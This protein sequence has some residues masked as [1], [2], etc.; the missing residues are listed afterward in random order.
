MFP[1]WGVVP[2]TE[3][4]QQKAAAGVLIYT[5]VSSKSIGPRTF[6]CYIAKIQDLAELS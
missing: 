5:C 4:M 2:Y 3:S 1:L 6:L